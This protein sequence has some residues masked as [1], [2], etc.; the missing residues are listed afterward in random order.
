MLSVFT[1]KLR[2]QTSH[3]KHGHIVHIR[4]VTIK[5][6]YSHTAVFNVIRNQCQNRLMTGQTAFAN[7][8]VQMLSHLNQPV[9]LLLTYLNHSCKLFSKVAYR[10]HCSSMTKVQLQQLWMKWLI[11]DCPESCFV[12]WLNPFWH[13]LGNNYMDKK[14]HKSTAAGFVV[15]INAPVESKPWQTDLI[16]ASFPGKKKK[17]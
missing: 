2:I 12:L 3:N 14:L 4:S 13:R 8:Y 11:N 1:G 17:K 7:W 10:G 9:K 6:V 16:S 15:W 5:S